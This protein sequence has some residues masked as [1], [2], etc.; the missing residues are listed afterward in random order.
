MSHQQDMSGFEGEW[1][2]DTQMWWVDAKPGDCVDLA[3]PVE[4][5]GRYT[6]CRVLH[7]GPAITAS[8]ASCLTD[9][10]STA[11]STSTMKACSSNGPIDLGTSDLTAGDHVLTIEITGAN[12]KAIRAYMVGID[13]LKLTPVE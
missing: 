9:A 7:Q 8:S 10:N 1:S 12:R 6:H 11:P 13:Y 4:A 2:R 3:L 5:A